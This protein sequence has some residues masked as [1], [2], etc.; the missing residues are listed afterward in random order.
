MTDKTQAM[1][2]LEGKEIPYEI[3][4][5]STRETNAVHVATAIGASPNE[6]FKTL[7]AQRLSGKL[8][9]VMIPANMNLNLKKLAKAVDEKKVKMATHQE[10]EDVTGLQIGGISAI[11]LLNQG[12]EI[13]LDAEAENH[14]RI[15]VSAGKRG[16]Q[17]R[18]AVK[19]LLSITKAKVISVSR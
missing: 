3:Y 15:Y 19:D 10:A 5:Y 9:L 7:V 8:M 1:R 17:I 2:I 16:I 4:P 14:S 12:F 6:V 11:A 18:L 13:I